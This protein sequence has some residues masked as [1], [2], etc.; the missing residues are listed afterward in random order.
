MN[1]DTFGDRMKSYERNDYLKQK[2]PVL[3]RVDGRAFHT[4]LRHAKKPFDEDV[5]ALMREVMRR[6]VQETGSIFAYQQS[7]EIS[8]V[9]WDG[10]RN[11]SQPW[12]GNNIYKIVSVTASIASAVF[13]RYMNFLRYKTNVNYATFDSRAYNI[14]ED[15]VGNY[16]IWRQQ[17]W[18][19][20]Y[21][22]M[23][24]RSVF[25]HK[26]LLNKNT[27]EMRAML[28][29]KGINADDFPDHIKYGSFVRYDN[30]LQIMAVDFIN[31]RN[32]NLQFFDMPR[33]DKEN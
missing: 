4:L 16:F 15:E 17:D 6:L 20:N 26:E 31:E 18:K 27:L 12:F 8:L 10:W 30:D 9:L 11:E 2:V 5:I 19:R 13:N 23:L 32:K 24:A 14:P 1:R 28:L 33:I 29:E 3:V 22:S 21:I 7:D 25:T